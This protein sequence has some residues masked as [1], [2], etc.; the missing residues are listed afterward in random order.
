MEEDY[1]VRVYATKTQIEEFKDSV[2]WQDIC[3]ELDFWAE[4]LIHEKESLPEK[5]VRENLSTAA[6]LI[7]YASTDERKAAIKYFKRIPDVFLEILEA[8]KD[9]STRKRTDRPE[10]GE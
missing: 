8:K 9:D 7:L 1:D 3:R 10:D 4:G 5:I 2:L 6:S